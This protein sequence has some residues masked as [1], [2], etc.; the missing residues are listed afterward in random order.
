[1]DHYVDI[2]VQPDPE[3]PAHQLMSALYAKLHRAL[4][5]RQSAGIGVSFPGFD[6]QARYLGTRLRLH[7]ALAALSGLLESDWLTGM[8]D[9][10]ALTSP[11]PVP[12]D[13]GHRIVKRVQV[14]SSPE[15][16]RRRLMRRLGVDEREASE[17]IPDQLA[18]T[19]ELPFVRLHS[20][21]TGQFFT[22]FIAHGPVQADAVAGDFNAYG[23]SQG[24][25]ISWF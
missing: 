1:M 18:C 4:V 3:F 9:H 8:R 12:P 25:T 21:S 14:K 23:L 17:R 7:G 16:L 10:V 13:A 24:A 22:L 20:T 15:R 2:D 6:P 5:A 11:R 19:S